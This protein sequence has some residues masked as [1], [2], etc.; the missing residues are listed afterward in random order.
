MPGLLVWSLCCYSQ[1]P[2]LAV[3][4]GPQVFAPNVISGPSGVDCLTFTPDGN[5]AFFDEESPH[6]VVIMVSHKV[7]GTWSVP[8][9]AS[10]SGQW[11]DHDPA[12]SP[13][14]S[15][16]IFTSNR[17]DTANGEP[18]HNG[19]LWRVNHQGSGWSA[20]V[21]L[22][23]AVNATT[24][25][26]APSV[27]ANGDV[28]FQQANSPTG[29]FHLY[30]THYRNKAYLAP[31]RLELGDPKA[32][33][34]DPAIAPDG[35]FLIFDANY[36][37]KDKPDRLFIAFREGRGWSKPIDMGDALNG[38]QP[39]GSHLGPDHRTLYFTSDHAFGVTD[40]HSPEQA[41]GEKS[42]NHIW[43]ISLAPWLDAKRQVSR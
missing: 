8:Q 22:P 28:Y 43:S 21:R 6:S 31:E 10:F 18:V 41:Q 5:T 35:S 33:E 32:H 17:P 42:S 7:N 39:W 13:D 11:I 40:P 2:V 19:H 3:S 15:V 37:G 23:D 34:L 20:P 29:D 38:Y 1:T 12:L 14:G 16:L 24:R 9:I 27:A 36:A 4:E 26:F 25:T 30:R